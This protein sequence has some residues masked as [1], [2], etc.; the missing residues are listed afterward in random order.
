[1]KTSAYAAL[2]MAGD[3]EL[4]VR[5]S[6]ANEAGRGGD[7]RHRNLAAEHR[8][9]QLPRLVRVSDLRESPD[10][11]KLKEGCE[12]GKCFSRDRHLLL[13]HPHLL[14]GDTG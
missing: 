11:Y 7:D 8:R 4:T 10:L 13:P 2:R 9:R 14:G 1:M 5:V 3:A 6:N 12:L